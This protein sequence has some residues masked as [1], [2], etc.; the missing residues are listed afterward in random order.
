MTC[1]SDSGFRISASDGPELTF[2]RFLALAKAESVK[3]KSKFAK[4]SPYLILPAENSAVSLIRIY[5]SWLAGF[6]PVLISPDAT[7]N[8]KKDYKSQL[9]KGTKIYPELLLRKKE[10]AGIPSGVKLKPFTPLPRKE[11]VIIFT[12]GSTGKPKGI[13]H[14]FG[15]LTA[16]AVLQNKLTNSG[17]NSE[18]LMS[19]PLYHIG[20][21]MIFF[22]A[23]LS[24][25]SLYIAGKSGAGYLK[26]LLTK[27]VITHLS[28]VP[29]QCS[30]LLR[31]P[32]V[33]KQVKCL[34]LGGGPVE[35]RI[36][37]KLRKRK[38]P[39]QIIYGS[40]ETAAFCS[41]VQ[42][43]EVK[44]P[45]RLGTK[46]LRGVRFLAIDENRKTL[47]MGK[48]GRI[49]ISSPG[50]FKGYT[51]G[52]KDTFFE[53]RKKQY[54]VTSDM[55]YIDSDGF[56][57]ITRRADSI[58]IT[59]GKKVSVSEVEQALAEIPVVNAVKVFGI[60]DDYWGEMVCAAVAAEGI[61]S[62]FLIAALK[63]KLSGFKIP[64]KWLILKELPKT[65]LG[66]TDTA[67]LIR[68]TG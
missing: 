48:E 52:D 56:V 64:K 22:R 4:T 55:G 20:G 33:F 53:Y 59:G 42:P 28:L 60:R 46:P 68:M 38:I 44:N 12:S 54:Y 21:F 14:T 35:K 34:L 7:A 65:A 50:L 6:T 15:S 16:S 8:E 40:S 36:I 13:I 67:A 31:T 58:I 63:K 37:I 57:H 32:E 17:K 24:G 5:A 45:K 25:S 41:A 27:K 26:Q 1:V 39:T 11:A 30:E 51:N 2:S 23:M 47:P 66:K 43:E 3:L 10:I 62:E 29:A 49:I 19:L 61:S 9:A 18:W